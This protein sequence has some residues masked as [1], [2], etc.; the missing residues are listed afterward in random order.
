MP[1][2]PDSDLLAA[3]APDLWFPKENLEPVTCLDGVCS[4]ALAWSEL[5][6]LEPFPPPERDD[7]SAALEVWDLIPASPPRSAILE[8]LQTHAGTRVT[9]AVRDEVLRTHLR[10]ALDELTAAPRRMVLENGTPWSHPALWCDAAM[11]RCLQDA[12]AACGLY[13]AKNAVNAPLV[14][15]TLDARAA[16]LAAAPLPSAA[17]PRALLAH[18]QAAFLYLLAQ[19]FDGDVAARAAA[20]PRLPAFEAAVRLLTG[21]LPPWSAPPVVD[22]AL[23]TD[24]AAAAAAVPW[25]RR[26]GSETRHFW[27]H[28]LFAESARRT[29][30]VAFFFLHT[31][32][33][34][35]GIAVYTCVDS[36]YRALP[37]DRLSWTVS[38]ELWNADSVGDFMRAW[39]G[40]R[41]FHVT[42]FQLDDVLARCR[43]EDLDP[44]SKMLLTAMLGIDEVES[45]SAVY[46]GKLC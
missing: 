12:H 32:R 37:L 25:G 31:Y 27:T 11:P 17:A 29:C 36:D 35:S 40:K 39:N 2:L 18:V 43:P 8:R 7:A 26:P 10:Y 23:A 22:D 38:A 19:L 5:F 34:L 21:Q 13:L 41:H 9:P 45:W 33:L 3:W 20:E 44:C 4:P 16:E 24:G 1:A 30:L 28:W 46:G 15:R 6:G 42:H 14:L